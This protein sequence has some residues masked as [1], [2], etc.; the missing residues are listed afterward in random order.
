[1]SGAFN[2]P[3]LKRRPSINITPLIDVMFLLLI[4]FMVSSTFR[5]QVGIEITLPGAETATAQEVEAYEIIVD[6][7]G[8]I[9]F[10]DEP[11][12]DAGLRSALA[13]V[14]KEEPAAR[15]VLR[16]DREADFGR[17]LRAM[18]IARDVG[19]ERLIIPTAPIDLRLPPSRPHPD[20]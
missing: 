13:R 16:A 7:D 3:R 14:L 1:M 17:A 11:V 6:R 20:E 10:G 4:F 12:D 8:Q 18:D 15:L 2:A 19:G 5:E 9:Y